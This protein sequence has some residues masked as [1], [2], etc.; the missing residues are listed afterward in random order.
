MQQINIHEAITNLSKLVEIAAAGEEIVIA[1]SGKPIA[2]R[3]PMA[4]KSARRKKSLLRGKVKICA[5]FDQPLPDEVIALFEKR[6]QP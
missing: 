1:E 6:A 5:K 3:V 2:R 4:R